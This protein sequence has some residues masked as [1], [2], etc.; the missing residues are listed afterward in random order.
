MPSVSIPSGD[1]SQRAETIQ[2]DRAS[3][4]PDGEPETHE[5]SVPVPSAS[6]EYTPSLP[7]ESNVDKSAMERVSTL[8]EAPENVPV[9]IDEDDDLFCDAFHLDKDQAGR[10]EVDIDR[11]DIDMLRH[12]NRPE[13]LAFIVSVSAAKKQKTEVKLS[14]LK[15]V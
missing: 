9:P 2:S 15:V 7:G 3:E 10:F 12:E 6:S 14:S 1:L 4:Q 5:G 11:W 8:P 13:R